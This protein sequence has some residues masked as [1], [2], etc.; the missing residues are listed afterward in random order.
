M[1][2]SAYICILWGMGEP[3]AEE[4]VERVLGVAQEA[5]FEVTRAQLHRWQ[6]QG[7]LPRPRQRGLGRGRG[8]E[9]LYP[10]GSGRQLIALCEQLQTKRSLIDACWVLWWNGYP[11]SEARIRALFNAKALQLEW[12]RVGEERGHLTPVV[13]ELSRGRLPDEAVRLMR[14]RTGFDPFPPFLKQLVKLGLGG[15]DGFA[16]VNADLVAKG[17]GLPDSQGL[18]EQ[19]RAASHA[20]DPRRLRE[21]LETSSLEDLEAARDEMRA[22]LAFPDALIALAEAQLGRAVPRPYKIALKR[23]LLENGLYLVLLW[24]SVRRSPKVQQMVEALLSTVRAVAQEV[25]SP[26]EALEAG[27]D[28]DLEESSNE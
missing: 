25:V 15:F 10:P 6:R 14:Q 11:V 19:L 23:L 5:G 3:V 4:T 22:V 28:R 2:K 17:F 26:T 8:T 21:A 20:Y 9:V 24:L 12:L 27:P 13:D 7:L 1:R 16:G 18:E